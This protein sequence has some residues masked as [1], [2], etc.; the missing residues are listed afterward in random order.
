MW[1]IHLLFSFSDIPIRINILQEI[2]KILQKKMLK[3]INLYWFNNDATEKSNLKITY[4][5]ETWINE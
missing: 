4:S 5:N 2:L 1:L 3:V